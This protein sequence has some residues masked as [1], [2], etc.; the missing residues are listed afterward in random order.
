MGSNRFSP[1]NKQKRVDLLRQLLSSN[2]GTNPNSDSLE[3]LLS[4]LDLGSLEDSMQTNKKRHDNEWD[5]KKKCHHDDEW[6]SKKK[7]HHDDEWDS[8]KKKH[9]D[10]ECGCKKKKHHDGECGC[11]K[12]KHHH[13]CCDCCCE[14]KNKKRCKCSTVVKGELCDIIS[15]IFDELENTQPDPDVLIGLLEDLKDALKDCSH[16]PQ[17]FFDTLDELIDL[18]EESG[19]T[20]GTINKITRFL[21]RLLQCLGFEPGDCGSDGGGGQGRCGCSP[22][23]RNAI[24]P[25]IASICSNISGDVADVDVDKLFDDLTILLGLVDCIRFN[26]RNQLENRIERLDPSSNSFRGQLVALGNVL[27]RIL[28][29]LGL[30][31]LDCRPN[32]AGGNTPIPN[33]NPITT[34]RQRLLDLLTEQVAITTP[35]GVFAGTVVA[36]QTDYVAIVNST[37]TALIPF[38]QIQ[39]FSTE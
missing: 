11:K 8:K 31:E 10:D 26:L 19:A 27:N 6:D 16:I 4:R 23:E 36:V 13:D 32:P 9:H 28:R 35:T 39:T 20:Q 7:R 15:D 5:S 3:S 22:S 21:N 37:G 12:K 2:L 34:V 25:V 33:P 24:A 38:D 17:G 30:P 14:D 1:E 29:C 18:L